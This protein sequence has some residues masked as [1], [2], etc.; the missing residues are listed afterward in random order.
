MLIVYRTVVPTFKPANYTQV[1][2]SA[3]DQ[4][5]QSEIEA[6]IEASKAQNV[7]MAAAT[8]A[9]QPSPSEVA[10][11]PAPMLSFRAAQFEGVP[12][13]PV[14]MSAIRDELKSSGY[15]L[16]K[17]AVGKSTPLVFVVGVPDTAVAGRQ[18]SQFLSTQNGIS[19]WEVPQGGA[20]QPSARQQLAQAATL[21][22]AQQLSGAYS[23]KIAQ[24]IY[25]ACNMNPQQAAALQ[26]ALNDQPPEAVPTYELYGDS[27]RA[28]A[29]GSAGGPG[30]AAGGGIS[31]TAATE[32]STEP[33]TEA[34]SEPTTGP[35]G[36]D[37]VDAIIVVRAASTVVP[38]ELQTQ[39]TT[40]PMPR[41][42]P[43]ATT[44]PSSRR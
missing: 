7:P 9:T 19:W 26:E 28:T 10:A 2:P 36:P 40:E 5:T 37:L 41:M 27:V 8:P 14:D 16:S 33:T 21:P 42:P 18:I 39:P 6:D 11:A 24:R 1:A 38:P 43:G 23:E 29:A 20:T 35:S 30:G 15:D 3:V 25:V 31:G 44:A 13:A 17:P 22:S 4:K 34:T 32:A 12:P